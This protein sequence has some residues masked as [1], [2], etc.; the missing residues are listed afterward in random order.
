MVDIEGRIVDERYRLLNAAGRGGMAHIWK[1]EDVGSGGV[2]RT[3]AIKRILPD[4]A[5]DPSLREMFADEARIVASFNHPNIVRCHGAGDDVLGPYL[6]L[7]WVDGMTLREMLGRAQGPL[8]V[9]IV[10]SVL[11]DMLSALDAIHSH[12]EPRADGRTLR[13]TVLHRDISPSNVLVARDGVAKLADFGLA[14]SIDRPRTAP[15]GTIT[16]KLAYLPPEV[17]L[18]RPFA[19]R[20]DLYSLGVVAWEMLAG[21]RMFPGDPDDS[22]LPLRLVDPRRIPLRTVARGVP[23]PI[24]R[25]ID[26]AASTDP[27][28]RP[29]SARQFADA[30]VHAALDAG[31]W[32]GRASVAEF[33]STLTD[34]V[35][36]TGS[37]HVPTLSGRASCA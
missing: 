17:L 10:V 28:R 13:A 35:S 1:A 34:R 15:R 8:P 9:R 4:L 21:R 24:A 32:V 22:Q 2:H 20:G 33:L 14:R 5:H 31:E 11:V 23:A 3:V 7:E 37:E 6:A 25:W 19:V 29:A 36:W 26:L 16:G 12:R 18:G 30:L 27:A